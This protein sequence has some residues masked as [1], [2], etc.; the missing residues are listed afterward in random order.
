MKPCRTRATSLV[1]SAVL[2]ASASAQAAPPAED[3]A[4]RRARALLNEV[5]LV[6]THNDLPW[7]LR[8]DPAHPGD[9]TARDLRVRGPGDTDIPRLREGGVG[10]QF[11]SVYVP[12]D[13]LPLEATRAQLEQ[14]DLARRLIERYPQDLG[15]ATS[16]ADIRRV[17]ASGRI[18]SLLGIEGG[19]VIANSLGALRAFHALGVRYM[20]LTHFHD[21][22]WADAATDAPRHGGLSPFGREV[23]REMNRLGMMVDISHVSPAAMSQVLDVTEAPV[24]FSH[25]SARALTHHVRNVP[26]SILRRLARNGGVVNVNFVT[27]FVSEPLRRW[28]EGLIPKLR[29][30]TSDTAAARLISDWTAA[31]GPMP[32]ATL[33]DL[34]DHVEHIRRVAGADHVG[35]GADFYGATGPL[36]VVVGMEDVSRYPALFAELMRRGWSD[37]DLRK[38]AGGNLLR[39]FADVERVAERL[40]RTRA[41]STAT[42]RALDGAGQGGPGTA[43][44]DDGRPRPR[45]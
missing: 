30:V 11:W 16:T 20:T 36:N 41:P 22:D 8:I 43:P 34:A 17:R 33:A 9:I 32:R 37:A 2:A 42:I 6:D 10:T 19:H 24:I 3:A 15:F 1:A 44:T 7:V 45:R 29:Q 13:V 12:S 25:S 18:A 5:G 40:Q 26:D 31:H 28:S 38:L 35:I 27:V 21:T 23:V 39:V 14:V 4:M